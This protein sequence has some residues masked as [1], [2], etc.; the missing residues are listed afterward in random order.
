MKRIY[1]YPKSG[2]EKAEAN[3]PFVQNLQQSL[4]DHFKIVNEE[5]NYIGVLNFYKYFFK[6]DLYFFN[7]I[8][9]LAL[10]K[11]G[12]FQAILFFL[13]LFLAKLSGKGIIWI[14]HNKYVHDKTHGRKNNPWTRRLFHR[15]I[16]SSDLIITL[17]QAGV[18]FVNKDFPRYSHK[19]RYLIHPVQEPFERK[20]EKEKPFDLFIWGAIHPYKG[21]LEFLKFIRESKLSYNILIAGKCNDSAYKE[22]LQGY[23]DSNISFHDEFLEMKKIAE[24]S[25]QSRYTLFTYNSDSVLSSGSLMDSIRMGSS[26]IGPKKGAFLDLEPYSFIQTF[27]NYKDIIDILKLSKSDAEKENLEI[28]EFCDQN[29]W[30]KFIGKVEK[31]M[32]DKIK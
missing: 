17:S 13:F 4:S 28:R 27:E 12:K 1:L 31:E 21:L 20:D 30:Q 9:A 18:E 23:L 25:S 8:E 26:I 19:V 15:M 6:T 3:N 22:E 32:P 11:Y 24:Y 10:K 7:W 16:R 14:M 2:R 29:T 5:L